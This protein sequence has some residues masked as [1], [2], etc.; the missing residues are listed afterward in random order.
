MAGH[1]PWSEIKHKKDNVEK[2]V[3]DYL[4][5]IVNNLEAASG[6]PYP[7]NSVVSGNKAFAYGL[8]IGTIH[9]L[10]SKWEER[11]GYGSTADERPSGKP[12]VQ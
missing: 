3:A 12:K 2:S 9:G 7:E 10:I 11:I 1:T 5:I 6:Y 8:A 4:T